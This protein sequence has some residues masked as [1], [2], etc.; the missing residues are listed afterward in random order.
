MRE[1]KAY[2][3]YIVVVVVV[4]VV[5]AASVFSVNFMFLNVAGLN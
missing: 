2:E 4:V 3:A 5:V 1:L